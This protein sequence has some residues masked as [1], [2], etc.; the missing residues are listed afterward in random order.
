[1]QPCFHN[2]NSY[3]NALITVGKVR[4]ENQHIKKLYIKPNK[5]LTEA[6]SVQNSNTTAVIM[7]HNS[8][9]YATQQL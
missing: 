8:C 6:K 7:Q 5:G 1:M 3:K 4:A 2:L 9:D